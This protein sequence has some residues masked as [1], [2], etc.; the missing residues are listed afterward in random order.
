[1][2]KTASAMMPL[3]N[4]VQGPQ[5]ATTIFSPDQLITG[6]YRITHFIG[7]GGMGEVFE[8]KDIELA[9]R[10]AL[11]TIRSEIAGDERAI[12]RFKREIHLA[13]QVSHPNVCR[14][15]DLGYHEIPGPPPR[16]RIT[17]LTMELLSRID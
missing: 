14:I 11:K 13:R 4:I 8:A 10:V 2:P 3:D 17:F 9:E 16:D 12:E 7:S 15:F 5:F 6:R 1:M